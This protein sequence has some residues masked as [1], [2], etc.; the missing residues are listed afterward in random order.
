M[1]CGEIGEEQ[2]W[3]EASLENPQEDLKSGAKLHPFSSG[4]ISDDKKKKRKG[5]SWKEKKNLLPRISK[6][7]DWWLLFSYCLALACSLWNVLFSD[8][9]LIF[10]I[11][12]I[13]NLVAKYLVFSVQ[14][15]G[16]WYA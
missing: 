6:G 13:L 3:G 10:C 15:I 2:L 7:Q 12:G 8:M 9:L 14:H 16:N 11:L 5:S 4:N 1:N